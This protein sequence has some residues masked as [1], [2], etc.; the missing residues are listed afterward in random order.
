MR[1]RDG[2]RRLV[3]EPGDHPGACEVPLA[4]HH[5]DLLRAILATGADVPRLKARGLERSAEEL[6][7]EGP[8]TVDHHPLAQH[9]LV[10]AA[11]LHAILDEAIEELLAH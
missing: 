6:H 8:V 2:R 5:V 1:S 10:V 9:L 11:H 3:D 7:S 4:A